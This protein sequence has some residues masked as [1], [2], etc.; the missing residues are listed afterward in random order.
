MLDE[1]DIEK[2]REIARDEVI[3]VLDEMG[4]RLAQNASDEEK[5]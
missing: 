5:K 4:E 2:I 3:K 1:T